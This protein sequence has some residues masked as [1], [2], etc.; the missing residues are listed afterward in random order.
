MCDGGLKMDTKF[1]LTEWEKE[2]T[3][4]E[5]EKNIKQR[6]FARK[7]EDENFDTWY[8]EYLEWEIEQENLMEN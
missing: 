3:T 7:Q 1:S 6:K 8:N 4:E 2:A 5:I